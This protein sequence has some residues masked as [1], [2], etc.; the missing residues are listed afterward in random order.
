[1]KLGETGS[2]GNVSLFVG[3]TLT[4]T[5][6]I[7][8]SSGSGNRVIANTDVTNQ[9]AGFTAITGNPTLSGG[10]DLS[11]GAQI[12]LATVTLA[13]LLAAGWSPAAAV[14]ATVACGAACGCLIG[15][16]VAGLG[17]HG[18]QLGPGV[19]ILAMQCQ[20]LFE[21][22]ARGGQVAPRGH[23]DRGVRGAG[24]GI[25]WIQSWPH[26]LRTAANTSGQR[27]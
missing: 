6:A 5:N 14:L 22:S 11:V 15:G 8:V 7:T 4:Y 1:V 2:S 12:A 25:G 23:R 17:V 27:S 24:R 3:N 18:V 20:G 9:L 21:R 19:G 16:L 13:S 26:Q 10:I